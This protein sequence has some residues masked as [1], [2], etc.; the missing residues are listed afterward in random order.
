MP[1]QR[2]SLTHA[3]KTAGKGS[4]RWYSTLKNNP[5]GEKDRFMRYF[6]GL[7]IICAWLG[8]ANAL[9]PLPD[10]S[11]GFFAGEWAGSGEQGAYC[12]L[13]LS[14]DGWGWVLI[15]D[16]AGDWLGARIQW[17]NRQQSLQIEKIIPLT[18]STQ[19]RTM[20]LANFLLHSGFNQS[21]SLTW[22][23]LSSGCQMQKLGTMEHHLDR[24]RRVIDELPQGKTTR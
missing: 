9:T 11:P 23:K 8:N 1:D 20:P 7:A 16:G 24:A 10:S 13:D 19:R 21:L 12:Y 5:Y 14:V 6:I 17:R 15:D 4:A 2:L 18:A 3:H 22:N